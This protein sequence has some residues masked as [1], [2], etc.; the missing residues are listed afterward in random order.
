[1]AS[2]ESLPPK[3]KKKK[4]ANRWKMNSQRRL[5]EWIT[6]FKQLKQEDKDIL[7]SK[8]G[9]GAAAPK[10]RKG[11]GDAKGAGGKKAKKEETEEEK[12][13]KRAV[14]ISQT[15][16][17]SYKYTK[18]DRVFP[19][20]TVTAT[21][22]PVSS[23]VDD[24]DGPPA[25]GRPLEDLKF[26]IVGK[27]S[28]TKAQ[29]TKDIQ[30]LGG[31]VVPKPDS[32]V[33]ACIS[34]KAEVDKK[35][36]A[37]AEVEKADIQVVPAE[38]LDKARDGGSAKVIELVKSLNI[39]SW[40][41]DP[42]K[43]IG[44]RPMKSA[45]KSGMSKRDEDRF[46]KSVP[47]TMKMTVKG[48]AAVDPSLA[49]TAHVLQ[50]KGNLYTA[51]LGLVDVARGSNSFYKLQALE[52]DKTSSWWLYRAWGRVG[53]T[54]GGNKVERCG[55]KASVIQKFKELYLDKT[56]NEW[57]N[58]DNF[59]KHPNK[60]FPLEID[61]GQ[62][63]EQVHKLTVT[64]SKSK[65]PKSVQDLICMIFDVDSMKKAMMEFEIDMKKMP[66][67]KLSK[68]QIESAYKVLTELQGLLDTAEAI[69]AKTEM[70]DNLLEI[71]VAYSLLRGGYSRWIV[72]G[73]HQTYEPFKALPNRQY[74]G[75]A[76]APP[77]SLASSRRT[78]YMFG[79]GIYFADMVSKS[80]NYCRTSKADPIGVLLLCEVALGNM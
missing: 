2:G 41:S 48:G 47:Q 13:L 12:Q 29:L 51:V 73:E 10:K 78:G 69:K 17:K 67:G 21:V 54:I 62:E 56:G 5:V 61:Y 25:A 3:E 80:A 70:L 20:I 36:K 22:G 14:N 38:F 79:K 34:T 74:C 50:D 30:S 72:R 49:E 46:T 42:E 58:R 37:M 59:K 75:M 76:R 4:Y 39:A 31:T 68:R 40:G 7:I 26:V 24:T 16:R 45:P 44:K 65:L 28:K 71:E 18:R 1:M 66:L 53:T 19:T 23:S 32:K 9:K 57:E 63:D 15:A 77:T 6:G 60:F 8:L 52:G 35:G 43:R 33:A 64:G 11:A 55:S 27:T